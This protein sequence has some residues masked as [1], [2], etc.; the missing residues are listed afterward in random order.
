MKVSY[1]DNDDGG[2][3]K[4]PST[5]TRKILRVTY[6]FFSFSGSGETKSAWYVGHCFLLYQPRMI[7]DDD[8]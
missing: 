1:N 2:D 3:L 4:V 6:F 7:D 8:Y 5:R